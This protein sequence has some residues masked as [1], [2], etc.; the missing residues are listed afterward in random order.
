MTSLAGLCGNLQLSDIR[1][2]F[3]CALIISIN[4]YKYQ[5]ICLYTQICVQIDYSNRI[6][7]ILKQSEELREQ[8]NRLNS[9][10][11]SAV[12]HI[13]GPLLVVAG[14][15][16]GKTQLL[17]LRAANILAT[18]DVRPKN[19]LCLTFS[20]AGAESMRKRLVEL[21][22]RDAYGIEVAT[23]H[24]FASSLRS[25][26]PYAFRRGSMSAIISDLRR[27]EIIN[28][29]LNGLPPENALASG[30]Q[31]GVNSRLNDITSFISRFKASGLTT[32]ELRSIADQND[33]FF[34]I[35]EADEELMGIVNSPLP[36]KDADKEAFVGEFET[37]VLRVCANA[38]SE[39]LDTIISVPGIYLPYPKWMRKLVENAELIDENGKASGFSDLR[40]TLFEGAAKDGKTLRDRKTSRYMRAAADIYDEYSRKLDERNL[41]D[42]DDMILDAIEAIQGDQSISDEL[43]N[44]YQYIQVDEFQDTNGAQ[45]RILELL[46][47]DEDSPNIMAVCDDDQAIMRF[48]GATIECIQQ[49]EDRWH[50]KNIV[51]KTNYRSTPAIVELGKGVAEQIENRLATSVA[52]K[53]VKAF[54]PQVGP[55]RFA[56]HVFVSRDAELY[57][58][59]KNIRSV[60]DEGFIEQCS[61]PDEAIAVIAPKHASL[62]SLIPYLNEFDIP[63]AYRETSNI[64][65]MESMQTLLALLRYVAFAGSGRLQ[66]A[67]AQLPQIVAAPEFGLS[68]TDCLLFAK[69]V[70]TDYHG[71]WIDALNDTD[72]P[73]LLSI[74]QRLNEWASRSAVSPVRELV[75]DLSRPLMAYYER[76]SDSDPWAY[77]QFNAGIR[78]LLRFVE[79]ELGG[80]SHLR[81]AVRVA[82]IVGAM[83]DL[84]RYGISIDATI[85]IGRE[86]AI[87][88]VSAHS[89]KGLEFDLV[90]MLDADD[91]TWHKGAAS[92]SFFTKNMYVGD[93]KDE[94]DARRLLFVALTRAKRELELYRADGSTLRELSDAIDTVEYTPDA[95]E[96]AEI[97]ATSWMERYSLNT[98]EFASLLAPELTPRFLSAS[99]LNDFVELVGGEP[100]TVEFPT[101][102]ML[103]LPKLPA[104]A[105]EFGTIVHAYFE[106]YVG[107]VILGG[108][109]AKGINDLYRNEISWLDYRED[110]VKGALLRFERIV[111]E[112]IPTLP[113][114]VGGI[115]GRIVTEAK[116]DVLTPSGVPLY[117]L[118]DLLLVDDKAREVHVID[119]KTGF[120]YPGATPTTS[121]ERQLRFYKLLIEMSGE[122]EG[123][124]VV[125]SSDIYVEPKRGGVGELHPAVATDMTAESADHLTS[126]INV[127]WRRIQEGDF[128]TSGFLDSDDYLEAQAKDVTK[129]GK[130]RKRKDHRVFQAAFEDWLIRK[131]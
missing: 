107:K 47:G 6:G 9:E 119:Y 89:S 35:V 101:K 50:P 65:A 3:L 117:G 93:Q 73:K 129:D 61:D 108:E 21:I 4:R 17:S 91:S 59:A 66:Y 68:K 44:T 74:A 10:Q 5:L 103:R 131:G 18:R 67:E 11:R 42:F 54:S 110:E 122:F 78:A 8:L 13:D 31:N 46:V 70:R 115:E 75:F 113:D 128:D 1:F 58:L 55:T 121:Y 24:S 34:D 94:D 2:N 105:S 97:C 82:D 16:T 120:N 52:D 76:I 90:Y 126:L 12:E 124:K 114:I 109:D 111:N 130:P 38:P 69:R 36:R 28:T 37:A 33:A 79:S 99:S 88:L 83:D 22:G 7:K 116:L 29:I 106:D 49:F 95:C 56:E 48:Q 40:N 15:G 25:K 87:R 39:L 26:F 125:S 64:F 104:M 100:V 112:F 27:A 71:R 96:A 62:K 14:P 118:C 51:L 45:M 102:R 63:F 127:V 85:S 23:F 57:S 86:G 41:Y 60:I 53:D 43:H 84:E 98:P 81:R 30:V 80:A 123:Y 20:N 32:A 92:I 72:N 77:A 19:I